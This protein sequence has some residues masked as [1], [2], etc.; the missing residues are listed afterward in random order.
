M[1]LD[2]GPEP[3]SKTTSVPVCPDWAAS[4]LARIH[5][6]EVKLGNIRETASSDAWKNVDLEKLYAQAF[7]NADE[8]AAGNDQVDALFARVAKGLARE[9]MAPQ[10]I[11]QLV[12][13]RVGAGGRMAY[14]NA[15]EVQDAISSEIA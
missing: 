14:C 10:A 13:A 6:L 12:N 4:L 7:D 1:D 3:R 15:D 8:Q 11:A 2:R 5:A 9:G